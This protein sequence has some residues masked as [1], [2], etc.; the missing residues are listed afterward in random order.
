M[1]LK[2]QEAAAQFTQEAESIIGNKDLLGYVV[3][4]N[5]PASPASDWKVKTPPTRLIG[6]ITP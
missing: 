6:L 4:L 3:N 2:A 5:L 1:A